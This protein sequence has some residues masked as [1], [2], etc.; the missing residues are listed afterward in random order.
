MKYLVK[1]W[2]RATRVGSPVMTGQISPLHSKLYH[3]KLYH[4]ELYHSMLY[5][6]KL[7]HNMVYHSELYH[8]EFLILNLP[9]THYS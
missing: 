2:K 8:I 5:H 7:Y 1:K 9:T 6:S 3:S 4:S